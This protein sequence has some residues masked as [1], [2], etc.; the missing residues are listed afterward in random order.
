MVLLEHQTFARSSARLER[1]SRRRRPG[2][3]V[4]L[5]VL[6][7]RRGCKGRPSTLR[8]SGRSGAGDR[9]HRLRYSSG[10]QG[11]APGRRAL[12][13]ARP[14]SVAG[15]MGLPDSW[16][17]HA[18]PPDDARAVDPLTARPSRPNGLVRRR[19]RRLPR[20]GTVGRGACPVK[21]PERGGAA[22]RRRRTRLPRSHAA[23]EGRAEASRLKGR[24]EV[25]RRLAAAR[26]SVRGAVVCGRR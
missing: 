10:L 14:P 5:H 18:H 4:A 17:H 16:G 26:R 20:R 2:V 12:L 21:A 7:L 9:L 3:S 23:A 25:G 19:A 6:T 24:L 11:G 8:R 1:R 15:R 13:A 22:A